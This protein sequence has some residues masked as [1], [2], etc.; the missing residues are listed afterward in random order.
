[1]A[2]ALCV[3]SLGKSVRENPEL[4]AVV[5]DPVRAELAKHEGPQG[6]ELNAATWIVTARS[7]R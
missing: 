1:L 2:L 3:G 6:V 4:R 7:S 5:I